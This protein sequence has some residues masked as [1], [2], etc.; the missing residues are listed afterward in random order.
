MDCLANSTGHGLPK[1]TGSGNPLIRVLWAVCFIIAIG[2][3]S[4]MVYE[5]V[6]Q[7]RRF[8]VNTLTNIRRY[9]EMTLPAVTICSNIEYPIFTQDLIL[10]CLYKPWINEEACKIKDLTLDITNIYGNRYSCLQINHGTSKSELDKVKGKGYSHGYSLILYQPFPTD[11]RFAFTDNSAR[12]VNEEIV[13]RVHPAQTYIALSKT[14]Q[15][16]L[17]P[18]YSKCNQSSDYREAN[19]L[20]E[21]FK[22][23]MTRICGCRYPDECGSY[24]M[25]PTECENAA[26][27]S[28]E[29]I[30]QC[31]LECPTRCNQIRFSFGRVDVPKFF[32]DNVDFSNYKLQ[33]RNKLNITGLSNDHI[34]ESIAEM[35]IYFSEL[36]TTEITQSPSMT[37]TNL[38]GNVGGLLSKT[39][40]FHLFF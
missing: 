19:C 7:F 1:I 14:H 24:L 12:V 23:T 11:I 21:C 13:E 35:K 28:I 40:C 18:P 39:H 25:W 17:G 32:K 2:I 9:T 6:E 8:E 33:I 38:F 10:N 20:D 22:K 16:A 37:P 26:K 15:I 34:R 3:C 27:N 30:S 29:I 36:E 4:F 5:V 31:N